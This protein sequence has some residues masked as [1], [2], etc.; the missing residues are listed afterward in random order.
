M[1]SKIL[2]SLIFQRVTIG[3]GHILFI[4]IQNLINV[5]NHLKFKE[6]IF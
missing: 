6:V 1:F 5:I 4:L 2:I 3:S